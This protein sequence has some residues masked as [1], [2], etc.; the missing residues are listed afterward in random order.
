[1]ESKFCESGDRIIY[2]MHFDEEDPSRFELANEVKD[3]N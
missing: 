3:L 1:M 2:R